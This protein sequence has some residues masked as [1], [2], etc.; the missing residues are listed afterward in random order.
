[1]T[2]AMELF[3]RRMIV[4]QRIPFDVVA[5]DLETLARI[6]DEVSVREIPKTR[7]HRQKGKRR[8]RSKG[9]G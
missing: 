7:T 2:D 1:M 9:G 4:D 5:L 6:T 3:L 8:D